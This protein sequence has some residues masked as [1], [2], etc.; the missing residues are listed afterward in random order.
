MAVHKQNHRAAVRPVAVN[1]ITIIAD[2][3]AVFFFRKRFVAVFKR[4]FGRTDKF[5]LDK[6][7]FAGFASRVV[8][9]REISCVERRLVGA[10]KP[11]IPRRFVAPIIFRERAVVFRKDHQ[12]FVGIVRNVFSAHDVNAGQYH[13]QHYHYRSHCDYYKPNP[14]FFDHLVS[15]SL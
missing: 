4:F 13:S 1:K 2:R 3:A 11:Q 7:E 5:G 6:I 14:Q 10:L 9:Y 12:H 15:S 8:R